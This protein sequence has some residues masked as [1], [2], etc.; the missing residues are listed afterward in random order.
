MMEFRDIVTITNLIVIIYVAWITY[1]FNDALKRTETIYRIKQETYSDIM[2][3]FIEWTK[4]I[5]HTNITP[6]NRREIIRNKELFLSS[7]HKS[8]LFAPKEITNKV[9]EIFSMTYSGKN[10]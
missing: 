10:C 9:H 7:I 6:D 3:F 5:E 8:W 1:R 2:K 4:D